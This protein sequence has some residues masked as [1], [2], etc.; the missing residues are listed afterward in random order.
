MGVERHGHTNAGKM[1][2][3][4]TS[5]LAM[6]QR[7]ENP[8]NARYSRY[9]GRGIKVCAHWQSFDNFLA[10][11]GE[12][13]TGKTLDRF[14][15]S[16]GDYERTNCRWATPSQQ[17][18]TRKTHSPLKDVTGNRYGYLTVVRLANVDEK[19]V[20]YWVC[21]CDCGTEKVL[22]GNDFKSGGTVSCGCHRRS[23]GA[24]S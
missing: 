10:D 13:P 12:R 23:Q 2:P 18:A 4:Y 17:Y 19:R 5:W 21:A 22:R 8:K 1:S 16:D 20:A 7:C 6:R 3:T 11:M 24:R 9:G 14:P 15:N